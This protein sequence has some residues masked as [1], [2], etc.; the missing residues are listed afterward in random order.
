[1]CVRASFVAMRFHRKI[2]VYDSAKDRC[3][4]TNEIYQL[5]AAFETFCHK[6]SSSSISYVN[7]SKKENTY[8]DD[9]KGQ[10]NIM[11]VI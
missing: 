5:F 7:L 11:L 1:M 9:K 8:I 3:N 6:R 2:E 4:L 10:T